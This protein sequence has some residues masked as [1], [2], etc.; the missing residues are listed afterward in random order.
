MPHNSGAVVPLSAEEIAFIYK[1]IHS[2]FDHTGH[3]DSFGCTFRGNKNATTEN[4]Q[5][6]LVILLGGYSTCHF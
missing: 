2:A 4:L 3:L 5:A 6:H 1:S